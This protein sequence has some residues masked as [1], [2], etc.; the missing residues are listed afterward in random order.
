MQLWTDICVTAFPLQNLLHVSFKFFPT[1]AVGKFS[2]QQISSIWI[3]KINQL[4]SEHQK[5]KKTAAEFYIPYAF[6]FYN[7]KANNVTFLT[8]ITALNGRTNQ[9]TLCSQSIMYTKR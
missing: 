7:F 5:K 9:T 6:F 2:K 3:K 8:L 1:V 4:I